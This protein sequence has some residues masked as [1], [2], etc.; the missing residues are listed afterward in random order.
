M[1]DAGATVRA[2]DM[3]WRPVEDLRQCRDRDAC[4]ERVLARALAE[5]KARREMAALGAT[6]PAATQ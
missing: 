4:Y 2:V 6:E 3:H 1:Q 5:G